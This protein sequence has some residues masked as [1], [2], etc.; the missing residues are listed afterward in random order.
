MIETLKHNMFSVNTKKKHSCDIYRGCSRHSFICTVKPITSSYMLGKKRQKGRG[1][2][3]LCMS[4][5]KVSE[6]VLL[7]NKPSETPEGALGVLFDHL[8]KLH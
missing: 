1:P 6:K 5:V 7:K 3:Y 2:H 8:D 4:H